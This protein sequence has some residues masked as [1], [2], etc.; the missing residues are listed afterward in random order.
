MDSQARLHGR[1][2]IPALLVFA[3]FSTQVGGA[4]T[5]L[6]GILYQED[7]EGGQAP[8]WTLEPGWQVL[9]DGSNHV[10][11]GQGH[12]WARS[13]QS[14]LGDYRLSFRLKVVQGSIHLVYRLNDVG[15]YFIGFDALSSRLNKQIWPDKFQESLISQNISH[16]TNTWHQVE[17][18]GQGSTLDFY[19]DGLQE[20]TYTD[21]QP[22]SN[23]SFA[24][25]TL[26][27]S[28]AHVDDI[29]VVAEVDTAI[30]PSTTSPGLV[31]PPSS[32]SNLHWQRLGGPLGGLGY[33]VRMRPDNPDLMFVTD[34]WAGVFMSTDGGMNWFPSSEGIITRT[35]PSGDAIPVFSLTIDP[36]SPE[37]IWAGTQFQRGIFKSV[38]GGRTWNK[39]DNGVVENEG[40]T[41]R[42]FSVQPG[43]S[44]VVYAAGEISSWAWAGSPRPGREFDMTRGV[45]YKTTN[46]GQSWRAVW[47]GANLARYVWINPQNPEI[48]YISTGF[49]DREAANS[50]P[51]KKLAGG[52]GI[53]KSTDGG[54]TWG[55]INNGLNNLYVTSLFMHPS[56]P[57]ILLAAAGNIQYPV[58]GGVYL[59]TDGG[60]SWTSTLPNEQDIFEAVEFS[61]SNPS[62]AYA[63]NDLAIY[64]SEDGGHTWRR[65]SG[66]EYWGPPGVRAGFPID[67]QVDPRNPDR[68]FANEYGGGNFLSVDGGQTWTDVSRGYT[69]AQVRDVVVDPS[70]P[71]RIYGAA[72]SGIFVSQDGGGQWEGLN[73][74][75]VVSMEWN[76]VAVDP[77]NPQ[78]VLAANN[79]NGLAASQDGGHS[80]ALVLELPGPRTG[81]RTIAFAPSG[82]ETV[83]AGSA[84]FYSAGVFDP[85]MPG[86]G[87]YVS[88]DGGATWAPANSGLSQDAHVTG[89][90]IDPTNPQIVYA[91]TI[92]H[93]LLKST[94]GGRSWMQVIGELPASKPML[95]VAI[96]PAHPNLI[97]GGFERGAIFK[98][99]D[100]GQSWRRAASGLIPEASVSDI[101]FDPTNPA[102]VL[103]LADL[104]SGVYRSIDGG[105]TWTVINDGLLSRSVNA[106]ALSGDGLHLYAGTEG[107]GVYRLDLDG[108]PPQPAFTPALPVA[109]SALPQS[110]AFPQRTSAPKL[111]VIPPP[112]SGAGMLLFLVIL[113]IRV[114]GKR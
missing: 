98:S 12:A 107:T 19:V 13:N 43:D 76:A 57:D 30:A 3:A 20:W 49:F 65:A 15:R 21:P 4:A 110:T 9:L 85:V 105:D 109:P 75:P 32:V 93:G 6:E 97:F 74:A 72:R 66:G 111:P 96:A 17:I 1:I 82:P 78:Q 90:A 79:W 60:E 28:Q 86:R 38:D 100:G 51:A 55:A 45:V 11:A 22:L 91:A 70:L 95:S 113:L 41:F 2:L 69:G 81:F 52:E 42:G 71:A 101:V 88:H 16:L 80:W 25:E 35:G 39:V 67:F 104:Q 46:G 99:T 59:T 48:L 5:N 89:L 106:L 24:F 56:N 54:Q 7:F 8:G 83:Y 87:I 58:G 14:F 73:Y 68:I 27:G 47:R 102:Q 114:L 62:I 94:D 92:N 108:Q 64:R 50:D 103:Y 34:A 26:D 23:G 10:L 77:R 31:S 33:D 53:L 37:T 112:C 36:N 40:I 29:S 18:V 44:N 84:G 63:G 61:S